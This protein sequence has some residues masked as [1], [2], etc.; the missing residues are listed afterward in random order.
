MSKLSDNRPQSNQASSNK[1]KSLMIYNSMYMYILYKKQ[2]LTF[3]LEKLVLFDAR[4][5]ILLA[6]CIGSDTGNMHNCG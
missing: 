6:I 4:Q 2:L 5:I 3:Y 1:K